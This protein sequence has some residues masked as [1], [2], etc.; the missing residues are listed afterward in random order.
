M[1]LIIPPD[2]ISCGRVPGLRVEG[3]RLEFVDHYDSQE[4]AWSVNRGGRPY[5][6]INVYIYIYIYAHYVQIVK[7]CVYLVL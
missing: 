1:V 7:F 2:T 5:I 6:F 4:G 3:S